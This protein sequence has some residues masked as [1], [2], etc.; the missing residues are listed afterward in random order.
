MD[1]NTVIIVQTI[2]GLGTFLVVIGVS[3][4]FIKDIKWD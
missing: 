1:D 3:V 2:L 4:W